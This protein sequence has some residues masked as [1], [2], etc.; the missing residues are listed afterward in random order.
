MIFSPIRIKVEASPVLGLQE[1]KGLPLSS[2]VGPLTLDPKIDYEVQESLQQDQLRSFHLKI[3]GFCLENINEE[4]QKFEFPIDG[5]IEL[6]RESIQILYGNNGTKIFEWKYQELPCVN[7]IKK[8]NNI[9]EIRFDPKNNMKLSAKNNIERDIIGM[10]IRSITGEKVLE[11]LQGNNQE[12]GQLDNENS[13]KTH[14]NPEN[15]EDSNEN[16]E[17]TGET[18]ENIDKT[19]EKDELLDK[20]KEENHED[21]SE[22]HQKTDLSLYIERKNSDHLSLSSAKLKRSSL[23]RNSTGDYEFLLKLEHLN[24]EVSRHILEKDSIKQEQMLLLEK[25]QGLDAR[26]KD[27]SEQLNVCRKN[28]FDLERENEEIKRKMESIIS[29]KHFYLQE[30]DIY[31]AESLSKDDII[32]KL[33]KE[34]NKLMPSFPNKHKLTWM[35]I[36]DL[37]SKFEDSSLKITLLKKEKQDLIE[38]LEKTKESLEE[39]TLNQEEMMNEL[40]YLKRK[41]E[42]LH[43]EKGILPHTP[44]IDDINTVIQENNQSFSNSLIKNKEK[45]R[46]YTEDEEK[47]ENSMIVSSKKTNNYQQ[48]YSGVEEEN[49][50]LKDQIKQLEITIET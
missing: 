7:M 18:H 29:Q 30:I 46:E 41:Y 16:K 44:K 14:E 50:K 11:K 12:M 43:Q 34:M 9:F 35:E 8:S 37:K 15:I 23:K 38:K 20:F 25:N 27:L 17:N 19:K 28:F 13:D 45:S 22:N 49:K 39:L 32:D 24:R 6:D 21:S 10:T 40:N 1:Y 4:I 2:E 36:E 47:I 26:N 42:S 5:T 48:I 3:D 31:K 33:K